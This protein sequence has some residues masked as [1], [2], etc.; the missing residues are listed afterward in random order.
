MN[1]VTGRRDKNAESVTVIPNSAFA[2][3]W[4][5]FVKHE[6]FFY[7]LTD[8]KYVIIKILREGITQKKIANS[9]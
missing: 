1:Q 8:K 6:W 7:F 5:I 9:K 4:V 3:L 2:H